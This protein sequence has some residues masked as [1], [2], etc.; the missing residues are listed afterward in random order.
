M[1][2]E[3]EEEIVH[4]PEENPDSEYKTYRATQNVVLVQRKASDLQNGLSAEQITKRHGQ[5]K[6][7]GYGMLVDLWLFA[8]C[9]QLVKPDS[10]A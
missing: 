8:D 3:A 1:A 10:K 5:R 4:I 6:G 9:L 2:A 7:W